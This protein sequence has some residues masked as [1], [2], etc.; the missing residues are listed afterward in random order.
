MKQKIKVLEGSIC[1]P[2]GFLSTGVHCGIKKSKKKDLAL[3]YSMYPAEAAGV[4]TKNK[5]KA[6]PVILSQRTVKRGKAQAIVI[7]SGNANACTGKKGFEDASSMI[8]ETAKS[9][10]IEEGHVL[11]AS[12]GII[13]LPMP[14]NKIVNG[15]WAASRMIKKD[16][17]CSAAEAIL[18][19]DLRKKEIALEVVLGKNARFKIAG[20][21]KGSG[22]ICPNMATMIGVIT[23]D[24]DI[25][26]K[27]LQKALSEAVEDSFNMI[28]VD[29]DMSTNDC[30]FALANGRACK[31]TGGQTYK[32]FVEALKQ[33]CVHL[34]KEIV[35]DGE[36]AKKLFEVNVKGARSVQDAR[37]AA[38]SIAGS[39]LV[40]CAV[41]GADPNIGRVLAAA[42]YSGAEFDPEKIE[43]KLDNMLLVKNG[44]PVQFDAHAASNLM[45]NEQMVFTV[46]LN[47]GKYFATAWGCDMT[48]GYIVINAKYHT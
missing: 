17:T 34:A 41:Y 13:G 21:A 15:I 27:L 24:A 29:N 6:A 30:V 48:E 19:T 43:V 46:N 28:T 45:K 47:K 20:I 4:F 14:M 2:E 12:T 37:S 3:I 38:K 40:K 25:D 26:H 35:R 5:V 42:G 1:A 7:N 32:M 36:G 39:S 33:V 18:T 8:R 9:L 11:V 23:T 31:V 22:M 44:L 10:R 16:P